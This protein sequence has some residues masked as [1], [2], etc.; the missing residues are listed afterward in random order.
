MQRV[1]V[2]LDPAD[3]ALLDRLAAAEGGTRSSELRS[4]LG[5]LRPTLTATVVAFEAALAA[6]DR[7]DAVAAEASAGELQAL[8]PELERVQST[9]LGALSRIEGRAAAVGEGIG[10]PRSGNHGGH[11][12][13]G[14][15][16]HSAAWGSDEQR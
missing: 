5:Q 6:R 4:I 1:S 2:T 14:S 10:D 15:V 12:S 13:S 16:D 9:V 11:N 3:V 8:M 7:L